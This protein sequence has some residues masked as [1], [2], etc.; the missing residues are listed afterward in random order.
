MSLETIHYI[1]SA[2]A[3][4]LAAIAAVLA[5]FLFFRLSEIKKLLI[6]DGRSAV[7]RKGTEGYNYLKG[8]LFDRLNDAVERES[9]DEIKEVFIELANHEKEEGLTKQDR[10]TGFQYLLEARFD[11]TR[12]FFTKIKV[13]SLLSETFILLV[14]IFHIIILYFSDTLFTDNLLYWFDWTL[15]L[16]AMSIVNTIILVIFSF[17]RTIHENIKERDKLILKNKKIG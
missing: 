1:L 14:I 17:K 10:P 16:F 12:S 11:K 8:L 7:R 13:Y 3:Q 9:I 15:I 6:G 5:A 4:V 2:M